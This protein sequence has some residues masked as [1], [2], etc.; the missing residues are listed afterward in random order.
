[1]RARDDTLILKIGVKQT[2]VHVSGRKVVI[3]KAEYSEV[4]Y[5]RLSA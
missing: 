3:R 4:G 2:C 5:V 1:M